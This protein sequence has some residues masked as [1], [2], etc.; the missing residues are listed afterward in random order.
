MHPKCQ[1]DIKTITRLK[2]QAGKK[3][4]RIIKVKFLLLD[5]CVTDPSKKECRSPGALCHFCPPKKSVNNG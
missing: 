5:R 3:K 2:Y 4:N 1:D